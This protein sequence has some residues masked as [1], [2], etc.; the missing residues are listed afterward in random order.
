LSSRSRYTKGW[1][2]RWP[3]RTR[4]DA[5]VTAAGPVA[6]TLTDAGAGTDLL[7]LVVAAVLTQ[8]AAAADTLIPAAQTPLADTGTAADTLRPAAATPLADTGTATDAL[9]VAGVGTPKTLTDSGTAA[10]WLCHN[11][12]PVGA[13]DCILDVV[14]L[15]GVLTD[16]WDDPTAPDT[17]W[18]T[19]PDPVAPADLRVSFPTPTLAPGSGGPTEFQTWLRKTTA[20]TDP[21]VAVEL[22]EAGSFVKELTT[23]VVS[24]TAG[25]LVTATLTPADLTLS[26]GSQAE[27]RIRTLP[28]DGLFHDNY[29]KL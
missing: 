22:W 5:P 16:L 27:L 7:Q 14:N 21:T 20:G 8:P 24:S 15:T 17:Q 11:G 4:W 9:T 2:R 12:G 25:Q 19:A 18:L 29:G 6:V 28:D 3:R 13:P 23:A 26:D 1:S 10:E